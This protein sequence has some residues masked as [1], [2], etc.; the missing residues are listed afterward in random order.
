MLSDDGE[1]TIESEAKRD[2]AYGF[3]VLEFGLA[4]HARDLAWAFVMGALLRQVSTPLL[5]RSQAPLVVALALTYGLV[6]D[7]GRRKDRGQRRSE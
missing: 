3:L 2:H 7:T 6:L 4:M 5:P 1:G